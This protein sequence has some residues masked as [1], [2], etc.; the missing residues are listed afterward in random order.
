MQGPPPYI[1]VL[2][3]LTCVLMCVRPSLQV[4]GGL[5]QVQAACVKTSGCAGITWNGKCGYLK[6]AVRETKEQ[7]GWTVF[8]AKK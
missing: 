6:T 3:P 5:E 4:C 2:Y 8:A 7:C 1:C